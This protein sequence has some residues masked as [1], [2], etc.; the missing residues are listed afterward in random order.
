MVSPSILPWP[1]HAR[2]GG[3]IPTGREDQDLL[4]ELQQKVGNLAGAMPLSSPP[5]LALAEE[6][7]QIVNRMMGIIETR[8]K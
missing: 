7:D 2:N 5:I 8:H 1:G 4:W 6:L 3:C